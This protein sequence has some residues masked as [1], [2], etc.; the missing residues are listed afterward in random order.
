ML[1]ACYSFMFGSLLILSS[2]LFLKQRILQLTIGNRIPPFLSQLLRASYS[3]YSPRRTHTPHVH[4][5]STGYPM[6]PTI[7]CVS[8]HPWSFHWVPWGTKLALNPLLCFYLQQL[9]SSWLECSSL[10]YT[11]PANGLS[12]KL[13][14]FIRKKKKKGTESLKTKMYKSITASNIFL[15]FHFSVIDF[16]T[17]FAP[18]P[19]FYLPVEHQGGDGSMVGLDRGLF[20]P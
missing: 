6:A 19:L 11:H 2:K 9:R 3:G 7:G 16:C 5:S 1:N 14:I 20:Q 13:V 12:L 17:C 4:P 8:T 10:K 18:P 15:S